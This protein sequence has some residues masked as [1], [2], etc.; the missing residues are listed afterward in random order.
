[1]KGV[2]Y[3]NTIYDIEID[4]EM[5][6][7]ILNKQQA[8]IFKLLPMNEEGEDWKK[9]LETI[10]IELLGMQGLFPKLETL[11]SLVFKLEGLGFLEDNFMA[12]R[13]TIFECCNLIDKIK[14]E[15]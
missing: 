15:L 14:K 7:I 6:E 8:L 12:F 9:P 10:V 2:K 11:I 13:R 3:M 4:N 5:L 1:M